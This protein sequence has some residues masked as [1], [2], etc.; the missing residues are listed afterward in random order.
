MTDQNELLDK[1][2]KGERNA[3]SPAMEKKDLT[4]KNNFIVN[5]N[6]NNSNRKKINLPKVVR[7]EKKPREN[8]VINTN[9]YENQDVNTININL[10]EK[11]KSKKSIEKSDTRNYSKKSR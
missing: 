10:T 8:L 6:S 4:S 2:K 9:Q 5:I 7:T 1:N 11:Y 3:L